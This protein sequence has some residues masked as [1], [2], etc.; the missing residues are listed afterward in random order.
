[1]SDK[2][3]P[4]QV[5]RATRSWLAIGLALT[6]VATAGVAPVATAADAG[7]T[8]APAPPGAASFEAEATQVVLDGASRNGCSACSGGGKVGSIDPSAT[9]DLPGVIAPEDGTYAV[10]LHYLS[11]DDSR[12]LT[13]TPDGGDTVTV[14]LA[15]TGGWDR[16]GTTT[17]DL[18]LRAGENSL[19]FSAPDGALGPDLDRVDVAG[20]TAKDWTLTDP[21]AADP[22]PVDPTRVTPGGR[23]ALI[24]GGDV[25]IDYSL[26]SGT[27]DA[28]WGGHEAV[29]GFYSGV[30]LGERFLTTKAYDGACRPTGRT[31]VTCAK[32]GL[33]T[34]RQ[35]FAFDGDRSFSVRLDVTGTD[36]PVTTSM[37]V[38]V[39]TDRRGSVDLGRTGDNRMVL[40]PFDNDHWVRYETPE[41]RDVTPA[42]RS[43]EVTAFIDDASRRGLV[44]G[45]LDRD[46]WKSGVVADGNDRGGLDRLQAAAGLTDWSYDYGDGM[47]K[48]QFNRELKPHA[49]VSGATVRSPRMFVGLYPDWREGMETF[50]KAAAQAAKSRTWDEGTPFG[51]NSW[52]GLGARGGDA[53]VMDEVSQFLAEETPGFRN[54]ESTKGAY[55]GVDSYWDKMLAPEYAFE[56]PDTSWAELERYVADVKARGQEPALYFQPFANFWREGLDE[57]IGGTAL[58]DTCEN[59][60]Y[61]EMA[62]KVNGVP[63]NIDGAWALDPTNPGVQNRA[64][65]ALG[66]FRELGV[67]YVKLDFLTH[68]YVEADDWYDTGVH[69]GQQAFRQG[70]AQVIDVA[71]EDMFVDLAISPLFA[72]EFAHARRISCDVHGALNNWH[73][74]QPDRYQKSTEYLLNSLT[75]GWWLD[76]VYAFNDGDHV[77]F[78]NYEYD[79]DA[80]AYLLDD[81]YPSIWP[82]GQNRARVT[83]AAITGIYQVSEDLTATGHPVIKQRARDLL[84][85]PGINHLAELGRSFAPVQAGPDA[86]TAS[87]TFVLHDGGTTYLALFNYG[88]SPR[89]ADLALRDLGLGGGRYDVTELWTGQESRAAGK[90]RAVV[91]G[92]DVRVYRIEAGR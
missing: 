84:Q 64:R 24:R 72:S 73:P 38:P 20:A 51:F 9:V 32:P 92:E 26:R 44:V 16:V 18:P 78:G 86:F 23:R 28:R 43:F 71:G 85:N 4:D 57:C 52:G 67:R 41:I 22:V 80:N 87:D 31:T 59:Q 11:G 42:R 49:E 60:T 1:M 40:V 17:V 34:L 37:M 27:A 81:P 53:D 77:Q 10:T 25:V 62:L 50:G 30:R 54:T 83:S 55:V 70:M 69:T 7:T 91:P 88:S 35:E 3:A 74:E 56:D 75:Y 76:E 6:V 8:A 45:S 12:A 29:T 2:P 36:G 46:T 66:K 89:R 65:I 58:C 21:D 15:S 63:V 5:R 47:N 48:Y 39:M 19:T 14:P 90:L 68:G 33:P 61:R 82:E 79:G 13:V